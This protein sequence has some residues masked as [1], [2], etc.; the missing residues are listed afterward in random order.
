MK[1]QIELVEMLRPLTGLGFD[2][3]NL[4]PYV[5]KHQLK[6]GFKTFSIPFGVSF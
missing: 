5:L 3:L 1:C 4:T 6:I 2:R